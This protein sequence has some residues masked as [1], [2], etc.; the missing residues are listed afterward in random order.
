MKTKFT[1]DYIE[2][3][4]EIF[5]EIEEKSIRETIRMGNRV[6][7]KARQK[8]TAI[9]VSEGTPVHK[10]KWEEFMIYTY[11]PLS[12]QLYEA[13]KKRKKDRELKE[14]NKDGK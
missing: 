7:S 6:F 4:M 10:P 8:K 2:R 9:F 1:D 14:K 13:N 3:L 5:P 12:L 11:L